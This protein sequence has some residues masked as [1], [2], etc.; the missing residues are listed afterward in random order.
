MTLPKWQ[1]DLWKEDIKNR[2]LKEKGGAGES[3]KGLIGK[4]WRVTYAELFGQSFV[5]S[6]DS[7]ETDDKHH[8]E[9]IEWHWN[10]RIALLEGERPPNDEFAYFPIWARGNMKTSIAEA[11]VVVDAVLSHTY[12]Q[13]GFCLYIGRE[14]DKIKE[15]ISNIEALLGS[16]GVRRYVPELCQVSKDQETNQNGRWT[17]NLL[18]T[19]TGYTIK[20]ATIESA[21]AGSKI[22]QTRVTLFL[23]DDIDDRHESPVQ[24]ET[25]YNKLTSEILPMRQF[26]TLTFFAQ[27]LINRFSTMYRI[28]KGRSL[29]LANRKITKPIPAVR[30]LTYETGTVNGKVKTIVT[31][32]QCTWRVWNLQ[33]VQDEIDTMTLP[34]FLSEMQHEV[35]QSKEGRFHKAYND[36]VHAISESQFDAVFGTSAW[37]DWYKVPFSD[38]SRTKTKNHANVAGYLAVS[39]ANT[40]Y[41]GFTICIPYSFPEETRPEDVCE[42]FLS[43]LTPYAYGSTTWKTLIDDSWK[44]LNAETHLETISERLAYAT[45]YYQRIIPKYSRKVLSAYRV[46]TGANSHSEDTVRGMF[47]EGFGFSFI[48]SNPGKVDGSD[49]IDAAM[50]V[51]ISLPH[52]FDPRKMG[53]TRWYVLCKDDLEAEPYLLNGVKV[54]PPAP[55]PDV[56]DPKDLHDDDLFRYQMVERRFKPP[57]LTEAGEETDNPEKL[58]DDFGQ[59]LQMVYFKRLLSNIPLNKEEKIEASL[60]PQIQSSNLAQMEQSPLK[61]SLLTRRNLEM[62]RLKREQNKP[63]RHA[64]IGRFARR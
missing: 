30:N 61:D 59:A 22:K 9:A 39:N 20:G 12:G 56:P 5:D 7:A 49:D 15:N 1:T 3:A 13:R 58:N 31:G 47:N 51:D 43:A 64:G 4:G 21:Q 54:Y 11:I 2:W 33:R 10:A 46:A 63:V 55:Y 28:Y 19:Q 24:A 32:G 40:K 26:N 18:Q 6:L 16:E 52:I 50:K 62:E 36:S 57:K 45:Q 42:R 25:K 38:W 37:K 14:K 35:E 23:P 60:A 29:A 53:Y 48:P 8:S 41:P 27:N 34:V 44:R 17:A